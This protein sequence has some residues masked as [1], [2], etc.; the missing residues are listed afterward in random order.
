MQQQQAWELL[1]VKVSCLSCCYPCL[2]SRAL[3]EGGGCRPWG[4]REKITKDILMNVYLE[5]QSLESTGFPESKWKTEQ[6]AGEH[7]FGEGTLGYQ[8]DHLGPFQCQGSLS[9]AH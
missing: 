1:E 8:S 5:L 9:T 3:R 2:L 4:L 7:L 6:E